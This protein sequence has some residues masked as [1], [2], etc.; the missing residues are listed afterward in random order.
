MENLENLVQEVMEGKKSAFEVLFTLKQA[1][2]D[3]KKFTEIVEVEA[4][5]Q[6]EYED[7]NF[8]RDG[9]KVEKRAGA[10]RFNFKGCS[11]YIKANDELERVKDGLKTNYKLWEQGKYSFDENG[12]IG[13]IPEV[14]HGKDS[15]ILKKS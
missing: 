11:N 13:E 6:C 12:E 2:K 5:N 14:T 4:F 3:I 8:V 1:A 10:K 9:Y 15:L 7:K